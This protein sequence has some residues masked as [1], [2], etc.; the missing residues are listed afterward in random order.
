M[1]KLYEGCYC[2]SLEDGGPRLIVEQ[3]LKRPL[4]LGVWVKVG[5]RHDPKGKSGISHFLEH[6]LF[7]GTK[8]RS[9]FQISEEIDALGGN[10][11]GVTH[12]E[13]TLL[14]V[15]VLSKHLESALD[16]LADLL[17]NPLFRPQDI[18]TERGV[19]LQEIKSQEDNP[20]ERI[21]DLFSQTVWPDS[22]SLSRPVMGNKRSVSKITQQDC[23]HHHRLYNGR[24]LG[25]VAVGDLDLKHLKRLVDRKIKGL[26]TSGSRGTT[27]DFPPHP[28]PSFQVEE[29]DILQTHLCLGFEGIPMSDER[30]FPLEALNAIFGSGMSSRLFRRIREELGLVYSISSHTTYYQDTGL[31]RVYSSTKGEALK[32]VVGII[33]EE[34]KKLTQ[35][36]ID[37]STLKTAKEKLKG[38]FLLGME[39]SFPRMM[40]LGISTIYG[41]KLVSVDEVVNQVEEI[42]P[43]QL[44]EVANEVFL[45]PS[46]VLIGPHKEKLLDLESTISAQ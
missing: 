12:K 40:R 46:L 27:T 36:T 32:K 34:A 9:S 41:R 6:L 18:E 13:Y 35:E 38:N 2:S 7:K 37:R 4:S 30:R 45:N 26:K 10:I 17:I 43:D 19:I 20:Q 44:E 11:N 33:L 1:E 24:N 15:N 3:R 5:S 16:V 25:L 31:V 42:K 22:T 23:F 28:A 8:S 29:K 39:G 14:Y 21:F